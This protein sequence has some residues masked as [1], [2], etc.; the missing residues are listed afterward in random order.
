VPLPPAR[1]KLL[2]RLSAN[3]MIDPTAEAVPLPPA[4]PALAPAPKIPKRRKQ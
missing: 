1:P 2:P 3:A 4:K